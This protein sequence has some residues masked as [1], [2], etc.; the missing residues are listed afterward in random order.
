MTA[1]NSRNYTEENTNI[2][3]SII[4][5]I[6][7][8][9]QGNLWVGFIGGI[10]RMSGNNFFNYTEADG[11]TGNDVINIFPDPK[12]GLW[13]LTDQ[14]VNYFD[15]EKF[16][17]YLLDG[18]NTEVYAPM[19]TGSPEGEIFVIDKYGL[20][21]KKPDQT[22]FENLMQLSGGIRAIQ[23][24]DD[25]LYILTASELYKRQGDNLNAVAKTELEEILDTLAFG[26]NGVWIASV[27]EIFQP[28]AKTKYTNEMLAEPAITNIL[29]DR[30]GNLWVASWSG[31]SM[32]VNADIINYTLPFKTVTAIA[33]TKE[34]IW[35]GR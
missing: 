20:S 12:A 11:L 28:D 32:I 7:E 9:A 4:R 14:G 1:K 18:I 31:V 3:G 26:K 33:K 13:I 35:A 27:S 16:T 17:F 19:L 24:H 22:Q 2:A 30:E 15:G 29:E 21:R 5:S 10:A 8:D 23:W 25:A 6:T 34:N